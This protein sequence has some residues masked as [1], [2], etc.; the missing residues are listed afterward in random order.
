MGQVICFL[1]ISLYLGK[2]HGMNYMLF[3][4]ILKN[5]QLLPTLLE[6]ILADVSDIENIA[7]LVAGFENI[8]FLGR[9]NHVAIA[10]E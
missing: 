1:I 10:M 4:D 5:L 8:F 6:S 7:E 3:K 9:A 2:K